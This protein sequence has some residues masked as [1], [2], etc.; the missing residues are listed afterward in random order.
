MH[1]ASGTITARANTAAAATTPAAR[2]GVDTVL[3]RSGL[4]RRGG[5]SQEAEQLG[6]TEELRQA[7]IVSDHGL[8]AKEP[9]HVSCKHLEVDYFLRDAGWLHYDH[10]ADVCT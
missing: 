2:A 1:P 8:Q 9:E 3:A 5:I 10:E 7:G 6:P 4:T